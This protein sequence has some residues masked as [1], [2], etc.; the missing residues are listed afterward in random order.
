LSLVEHIY[1]FLIIL[2]YS[3]TQI[4]K[5]TTE[6]EDQIEK[7]KRKEKKPLFLPLFPKVV[8]LLF[9]F[10]FLLELGCNYHCE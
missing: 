7:E 3:S 10:F 1:S 9:F 5:A 8:I 2:S 4:F 6:G